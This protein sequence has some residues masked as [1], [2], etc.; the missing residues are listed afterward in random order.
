MHTLACLL[1]QEAGSIAVP[2]ALIAPST[3]ATHQL[4]EL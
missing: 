3:T 4:G 2:T 1:L